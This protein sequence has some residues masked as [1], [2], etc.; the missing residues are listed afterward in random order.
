MAG[1]PRELIEAALFWNAPVLRRAGMEGARAFLDALGPAPSLPDVTSDDLGLAA[2]GIAFE[3]LGEPREAGKL[4]SSLMEVDEPFVRALGC[5]LWWWSSAELPPDFTQTSWDV[6]ADLPPGSRPRLLAKLATAA[7][8]RQS[9]DAFRDFL[10][11]AH[12]TAR[13]H[14][15]LRRALAVVAFNLLRTPLSEEDSA[16][17]RRDDPLV[18][19]DWIDALALSGA[20]GEIEREL[21]DRAESP[22]SWSFRAGQTPLDS[23]AAAVVQASWAGALWKLPTL[24]RQVGAQALLSGPRRSEHVVYGVA[25][26]LAGGGRQIRQIVSLAEPFFEEDAADSLVLQLIDAVAVPGARDSTIAETAAA[27]WDLLS[28][29]LLKRLLRRLPPDTSVVG[30]ASR[31]VWAQAALRIPEAWQEAVALLAPAEQASLIEAL[32]PRALSSISI[33]ACATLL[34]AYDTGAFPRNT[35]SEAAAIVLERRLRGTVRSQDLS[36]GVVVEVAVRDGKAV[37]KATLKTA[38]VELCQAL[39]AEIDAARR[40]AGGLGGRSTS[41]SLATVALARGK[42]SRNAIEVLLEAALDA[43]LPG[44]LRLEALDGL[45]R[46]A[47]SSLLPARVLERLKEVPDTSRPSFFAPSTPELVRASRLLARASVL[48][49]E[50]QAEALAL[51]RDRDERVRQVI[52]NTAS[53]N[54]ATQ[55]SQPAEMSLLS[56]LSDPDERVVR[57][58][59]R[60]VEAAP[61]ISDGFAKAVGQRLHTLFREYGR[62]VRAGTVLAA[63]AL[64]SRGYLHLGLDVLSSE[65]SHDRSWSVREACREPLEEQPGDT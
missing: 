2:R 4:A 54:I 51:S 38:E 13:R 27:T 36:P 48:T 15:A 29:A 1:A 34:N 61:F 22:W 57:A 45:A 31:F 11:E 60:G 3:R 52:A 49:A 20:R 25:M 16:I 37:P 46:L 9:E 18:D 32:S 50:E 44:H 43:E 8:D 62:D 26:W 19:L 53:L 63:R 64:L 23:V 56:A 42:V 55:W 33:D 65:A 14:P 12:R 30:D 35:E 24:Q 28:D 6:V 7:R 41:F 21:K 59:L 40:G 17:P 10:V 39:T 5:S 58:A 47:S